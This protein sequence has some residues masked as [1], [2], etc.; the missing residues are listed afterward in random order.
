[1]GYVI[2][3]KRLIVAWIAR[4]RF[5]KTGFHTNKHGTVSTTTRERRRGGQRPVR[6]R[7]SAVDLAKR[8]YREERRLGVLVHT[9][10]GLRVLHSR[11]VLDGAADAETDVERR[12]DHLSRLT[13]L[14]TRVHHLHVHR[15]SRSTH[16]VT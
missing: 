15:R 3:E 12:R 6:S 7:R 11:L 2:G 13:H 5:D 10:D 9:H 1:M 4:R 8:S 16:Y 14:Q